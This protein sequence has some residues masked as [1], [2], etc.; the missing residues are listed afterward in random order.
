MAVDNSARG[1]F[2]VAWDYDA[3][4][5]MDYYVANYSDNKVGYNSALAH[6]VNS[7]SLY[8]RS[9]ANG[10]WGTICL[11]WKSIAFEGAL[12]YNILGTKDA[13]KGIAL[14]PIE[15]PNQL[16]AGKPYVLERIR[17]VSIVRTL[18]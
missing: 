17:L 13:E 2:T 5:A 3:D 11:P 6:Q 8:T 16:Q 12:F 14:E 10:S 9:V 18:M 1:G 4:G 15:E 7:T